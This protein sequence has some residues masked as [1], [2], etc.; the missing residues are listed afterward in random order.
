MLST[1]WFLNALAT[2]VAIINTIETFHL[3]WSFLANGFRPRSV[4]DHQGLCLKTLTPYFTPSILNSVRQAFKAV[5]G[6]RRLTPI[7][8]P[9]LCSESRHCHR[10]PSRPFGCVTMCSTYSCFRGCLQAMEATWPTFVEPVTVQQGTGKF[11]SLGTM[12]RPHTLCSLLQHRAKAC[13]LQ[14]SH[15]FTLMSGF[16]PFHVLLPSTLDTLRRMFPY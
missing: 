13:P 9:S 1:Y 5:P 3:E 7:M 2:S 14:T 8:H 6:P 12:L 11:G 4:W 10:P 15:E 16:L